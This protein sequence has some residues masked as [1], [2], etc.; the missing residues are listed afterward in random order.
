M[1]H[2]GTI[3]RLLDALLTTDPRQRIRLV[4]CGT[5]GLLMIASATVALVLGWYGIVPLVPFLL[6]AAVAVPGV[7]IFF[8][9]VRTGANRRFA[10]QS[11]TM[12]Q[13]LFALACGSVAYGLAGRARGMALP[14]L[15]IVLM[16]GIF[17][18]R[19]AQ[20]RLLS[21]I[22]IVMIGSV[23][24]WKAATEP[25]VYEPRIELAHFLFVALIMPAVA[26]LA[27]QLSGLRS[28]L[29][30][31]K[32]EL[33]V[34]LE[35]IQQQAIRDDLTGLANRRHMMEMLAQEHA[36]C[37]RSGQSFCIALLDI[38]HFKRVND[39]HGHAVGDEVLKV[40]AGIGS[41]ELRDADLLARWGGEEF[42][43][44]MPDTPLALARLALERLRS[45]VATTPIELGGEGGLRLA[46][47]V[48]GGLAEYW[49]QESMGELIERA[50]RALYDA[51][52]QGRDRVVTA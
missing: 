23:M 29:N 3:A 9:I 37:A 6:W 33:A 42:L 4:Q 7:I 41:A 49:P 40:F 45:K 30:D 2:R 26:V 38:D 21:L 19:P 43:V 22:G 10:E 35:R 14:N 31:Q 48:S 47:T 28:R 25:L 5:A 50:D 8:V 24:A 27:G 32:A 34:A 17:V 15:M 18:L 11:L 52:D 13:M 12:P 16:F 36:R 39:A 51:K 44:L 1:K 20:L 46:I